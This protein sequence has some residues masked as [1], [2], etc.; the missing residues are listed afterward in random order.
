MYIFCLFAQ[1][2]VA[3][4]KWF[5]P[6]SSQSVIRRG[7]PNL[8]IVKFDSKHAWNRSDPWTAFEMI[9]PA[10]ILFWTDISD[11]SIQH[12]IDDDLQWL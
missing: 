1:H 3:K 12:V 5:T 2:L 10:N 4:V 7:A 6:A 11:S 8:P 9:H